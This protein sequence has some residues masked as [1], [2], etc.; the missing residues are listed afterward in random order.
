VEEENKKK[1][2]ELLFANASA[3]EIEWNVERA[4]HQR[5]SCV[6]FIVIIIQFCVTN[7]DSRKKVLL[8]QPFFCQSALAF[9]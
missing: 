8:I 4:E 5:L 1:Q 3:A 7:H 9:R 6:S 2:S